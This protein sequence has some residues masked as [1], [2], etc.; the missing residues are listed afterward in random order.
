MGGSPLGKSP[1]KDRDFAGAYDRLVKDYFSGTDSVYNEQDFERRFRMPRSIFEKVKGGIMGR[2]SFIQRTDCTGKL[3]I[4]PLCRLTA[5]LRMIAYGECA[6]REDEYLRLSE[7]VTSESL[8]E[9]AHHVVEVFGKQY[10]CRNPTE[11]ERQRILKIF[12]D[13]GFPGAFSSWDCKHFNWKNCP[14][15]LA[16]QHKGHSEGG[17]KTLILETIADPDLYLWS[18]FFGEAGSLNDINVLDKSSIVT[19]ILNG[20]F[21]LKTEEYMINGR[22]RDWLYFLVD[23]VYPNWAIFIKSVRYPVD[24]IESLFAECHEAARKD[25][26]RAFGVL[27][28]RF[29]ILQHPIRMWYLDDICNLL[30]CCIILHNMIVEER[31]LENPENAAAEW[32]EEN[33]AF[34]DHPREGHNNHDA[35]TTLFGHSE[36]NELGGDIGQALADRVATLSASMMDDHE[37]FQLQRDIMQHLWA[38]RHNNHAQI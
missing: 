9:F 14:V 31:R 1:N 10:L 23:G 37:H 8:K 25:V 7:S 5:V 24:E 19:S 11:Q 15:R 12:M 38:S 13:R 16:G 36:I 21:D 18:I 2:G 6:D 17:K 34:L 4:H 35:H 26:E 20:K 30:Y 33:V 27:V 28:L 32:M 22:F 3:G 29:M